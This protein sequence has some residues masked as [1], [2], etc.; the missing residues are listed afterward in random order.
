MAIVDRWYVCPYDSTVHP[1][2]GPAR[3]AA[4][5]RYIPAVPG[6]GGE[7]WDEAEILGNHVVVKV[8]AD[9][10]LHTTILADSDFFEIPVD[11]PSIPSG[12]RTA[13]RIRLLALGYVTGEVTGTNYSVTNILRLLTTAA[14]VVTVAGETFTPLPARRVAPKTVQDIE[15]RLPT[16]GLVVLENG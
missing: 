9:D 5:K 2:G 1:T 4:I 10:T 12:R 7:N 14:S 16:P 11:V 13:L 15:N 3:A 8:R 6:P